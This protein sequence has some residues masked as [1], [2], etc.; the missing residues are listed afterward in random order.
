M[1][2]LRWTPEHSVFVPEIDFQHQEVF[3]MA[4]ELRAAVMAGEGGAR[5]EVLQGRLAVVIGSHL[6]HEEGLMRAAAY[7]SRD[8]HERQHQTAR[9]KLAALNQSVAHGDHQETFEALEALAGWL[10]DHTSI[11]DRMVGAYLRNHQRATAVIR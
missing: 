7:P 10:R 4:A 8:W 2:S 5:L 3:A 6:A 11:A 1:R 9:A